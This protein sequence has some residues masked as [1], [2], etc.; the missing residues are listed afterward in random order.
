[1]VGGKQT[2]RTWCPD[3]LETYLTATRPNHLRQRVWERD[4]G[5][6]AACGVQCRHYRRDL[7]RPAWEADHIIPLIDA[8][9]DVWF[10][11]LANV[12]TLC[13]KCHTRITAEQNAA[14]AER[15]K[16]EPE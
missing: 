3:C 15:R 4:H 11:T 12:R 5:V 9:R 2:R 1:M 8:P 16:G 7:T 6:C 10:W 13:E 14:R